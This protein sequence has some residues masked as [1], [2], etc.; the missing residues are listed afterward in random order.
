MDINS[1]QFVTDDQHR[2]FEPGEMRLRIFRGG[3]EVASIGQAMIA[4]VD[5]VLLDSTELYFR[6]L[7]REKR[8]E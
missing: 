4:A 2:M 1:E 5:V 3:R 7:A 8:A 6:L